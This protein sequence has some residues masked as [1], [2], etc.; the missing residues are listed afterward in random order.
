MAQALASARGYDHATVL[1]RRR[2]AQRQ[3]RLGATARAQNLRNAFA[4]HAVDLSPYDVLLVDD[5]KTTGA[6][7]TACTRIL[8]RMGAQHVDC[9]VAAVTDP[10][11]L[12]TMTSIEGS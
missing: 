3:A 12:R 7:L 6:T 1:S 5:I 4:P 8:K 9:A 11:D 2:A 10:P